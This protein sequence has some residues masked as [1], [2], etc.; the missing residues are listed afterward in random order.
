MKYSNSA[1]VKTLALHGTEA[2]DVEVQAH[3]SSGLPGFIICGLPDKAISESRDRIRSAFAHLGIAFV[4]RRL[5][6]NMSP[7]N[8][9][10]EGTH[11]DLP[12]ALAI[13]KVMDLVPKNCS[14][15]HLVIGEL[16]LNGAFMHVPGT[17]VSAIHAERTGQRLI[18]PK[19]CEAEAVVGAPGK[20]IGLQNLIELI[21]YLNGRMHI[22]T[23]VD[24]TR[25]THAGYGKRH[26]LDMSDVLGHDSA[27]RALEIA[28]AGGHHIL[29]VGSPGVG[30]S[31]LAMRML[32][33]LPDLDKDEA[34]DT[35]AIYSIAGMMQDRDI[36]QRPFRDPHHN[37]SIPA[38]L[39]GGQNASPGEVSLAN[40]GILFMDEL[41]LW[42]PSVLNGLRESLETGYITVSR[43][44]AHYKY[45]A[46]YQLVAAANP[47]P[48]GKA[49]DADVVC[50][51]LPNC[52]KNYLQR[53]PGPI[54]DRIS[55]VISLQQQ[56]TWLLKNLK[57]SESS[58]VIKARVVNA[59]ARQKQRYADKYML[60]NNDITS[61]SMD[62]LHVSSSALDLLNKFA[63]KHKLS[64]RGYFNAQKL[65]RT[66][67][68]LGDCDDVKDEHMLEALGFR[69]S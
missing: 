28:A 46:R 12:I 38:M 34:I 21:E 26:H 62:L 67:A 4:S 2:I 63:A 13:L 32:S 7:A 31:M 40:N 42:P 53:I 59:R 25:N 65:A 3:I 54:M 19:V 57:P 9:R 6:I 56:E 51:K 68:D 69:G 14:D 52:S 10:K 15:E 17:L 27:K 36:F 47:C 44:N 66:I 11:Y 48:C 24:C 41:T 49:Y 29:M 18:C 23:A 45:K 43:A 16:S 37:A 55:L 20:I 30:K 1:S 22:D 60:L 61:A 33:I 5:V 35:A 8:I 39:G 58:E 64:G 50:S